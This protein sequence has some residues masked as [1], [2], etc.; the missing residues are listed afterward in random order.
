MNMNFNKEMANIMAG[1][2][3]KAIHGECVGNVDPYIEWIKWLSYIPKFQKE[4]MQYLNSKAVEELTLEEIDELRTY[5][6]QHRM[7]ELFKIYGTNKISKKEYMEVYNF[8]ESESIDDLMLS[9]LSKQEIKYAKEQIQYFSKISNE[10]L[11]KKVKIEQKE[12]NYQNLP[13]VDSYI[14]HII[15]RI[16]NTRNTAKL[17]NDIKRELEKNDIMLRRSIYY[18]ANSS[19]SVL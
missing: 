3:V 13:M 4:R 19:L 7:L 8:M 2:R 18:A 12:E 15:S 6:Y 11:R 10:E 9:K 14:L 17:N 5:R 1:S 16:D